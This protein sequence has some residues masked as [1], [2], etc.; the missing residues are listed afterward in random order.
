MGTVIAEVE[1]AAAAAE[2]LGGRVV[3]KSQVKDRWPRQGRRGEVRR[4]PDDAVEKAGNILGLDIKGHSPPA[5]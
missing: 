1:D 5:C 4:D 3:V 2:E